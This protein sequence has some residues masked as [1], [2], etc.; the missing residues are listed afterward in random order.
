[1][2]FINSKIIPEDIVSER[3]EFHFLQDWFLVAY[4]LEILLLDLGGSLVRESLELGS[5]AVLKASAGL[6]QDLHAVPTTVGP[7]LTQDMLK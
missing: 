3:K 4:S 2:G 1:M 7:Q 5:T 6:T